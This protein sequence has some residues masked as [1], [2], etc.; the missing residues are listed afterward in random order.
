[1]FSRRRQKKP[2][3]RKLVEVDPLD[4]MPK[5]PPFLVDT[6]VLMKAMQLMSEGVKNGSLPQKLHWS[7]LTEAER[8][9]LTHQ[10]QLAIN[11]EKKDQYH[12]PI[13]FRWAR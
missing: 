4:A 1:M 11:D 7:E 2:E 3:P 12:K 10:A 5:A 9:A 8:N 6:K 13:R